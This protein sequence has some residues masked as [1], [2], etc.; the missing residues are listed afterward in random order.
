MDELT[1]LADK[2]QTDKSP[3]FREREGH[4]YTPWYDQEF[5]EHR[6]DVQRVF[7]LGINSGASIYMWEE[8]FSNAAIYA[9]DIS[10]TGLINRGRI[11][12]HFVDQHDAASLM[13]LRSGLPHGIDLMIDDG[14][15]DPEDQA[16]TANILADRLAP[17]GYYVI[18]D[19]TEGE[20]VANAILWPWNV[21]IV[22]FDIERKKDDR[23]V[24][25]RRPNA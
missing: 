6:K 2:Y 15:H 14:N 23:L 22:E 13:E 20:R 21:T 8:Y 17:G 18:E 11:T 4:L 19:V 5:S 12:S 9:A 16:L 24:V 10:T 25:I 1:K 3:N 7:E